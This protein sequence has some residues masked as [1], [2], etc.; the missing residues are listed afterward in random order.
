MKCRLGIIVL[1]LFLPVKSLVAENLNIEKVRDAIKTHGANWTAGETSISILSREEQKVRLG[2][3][4]HEPEPRKLQKLPPQ[5]NLPYQF[6]WRDNGGDFVTPVRDQGQCGACSYF[7]TLAA[8]EAW[9]RIRQNNPKLDIDLSEQYVLSCGSVGNCDNGAYIESI[10]RFVQR[11]GTVQETCF[12]YMAYDGA[13]CTDACASSEQ[14]KVKIGNFISLNYSQMTVGDIKNAVFHRPVAA[15]MAIFQDFYTYLDGVYQHVEGDLDGYHAV[16]IYGWDDADESWLCKNSWGIGWGNA[17]FFKIKWNE[18]EIGEPT[19]LIWDSTLGAP[20]LKVGPQLMQFKLAPG[21]KT[22]QY[23]TISN[24]G[25]GNLEFVSSV[26]ADEMPRSYFR[27]TKVDGSDGHLW[28]VSSELINGY[29]NGWLQYLDSPALD[30][31]QAKK[32]VLQLSASWALEDMDCDVSGYDGWD[33]WNVQISTDNGRTFKP[34]SPENAD[35]NCAS[36]E[37]FGDYWQLGYGIKG[38]SGLSDGWQNLNFDLTQLKSNSTIIRF[39]FASNGSKSSRDLF[40][41]FGL[42]LDDVIVKDSDKILFADAADLNSTMQ[43][44]GKGGG[45]EKWLQLPFATSN[46][47][48]G[49]DFLVPL[50]ISASNNASGW[51]TA[52]IDVNNNHVINNPQKV[53]LHL[54]VIKP[55]N[56]VGVGEIN[57]PTFYWPMLLNFT[58]TFPVNNWGTKN[59]NNVSASIKVYDEFEKEKASLNTEVADIPAG[60]SKIPAF[61]KV[62]LAN[63]GDYLLEYG[64]DISSN[65]ENDSNNNGNYWLQITPQIDDFESEKKY[66]DFGS[67]WGITEKF[68]GGYNSQ[69][70]VHVN[71]GAK[72]T[73]N[74]DNSL[75]LKNGFDLSEIESVS[76]NFWARYSMEKNKD[77]VNI[78]ARSGSSDWKT[79][80]TLSS[81]ALRWG[82]YTTNLTSFCGPGNNEVFI[83][84]QF[85][86]DEQNTGIGFFMDDLSIQI[87]E[88]TKSN[89]IAGPFIPENFILEQNYPNPFNPTTT[90]SYKLAESSQ[91]Q[92]DVLNLQGQTV[93]QLTN[94]YQVAGSHTIEWN[95]ADFA[96][97]VYLYKIDVL[98][99]TG[100]RFMDMKKMLLVK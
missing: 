96:S 95:A 24:I 59:A 68:T 35:Y 55:N 43:T 91:V 20:I 78:Q 1:L 53:I 30:L 37:S 6:S 69:Y 3:L 73:N 41:R 22:T 57:S 46:L 15:G 8:V 11:T 81:S 86:S 38:F 90:I 2:L 63:P 4:K 88:I 75:T 19:I 33:G 67:T 87:N 45:D 25:S 99:Q 27:Q 50:Q 83:R 10:H 64:L 77:F 51:Y 97:G 58:P 16:L 49:D 85:V 32:P 18:A 28:W 84:F 65:D 29:D 13:P 31:S 42:M 100:D 21:E 36:L 82:Q 98:L 7:S 12:P 71:K 79:L 93:A 39:A 80:L 72:Y 34:V 94:N 61:S 76:L 47:S 66:W 44:S 70:A 60:H 14:H 23:L 56:D 52:V 40:D 5:E 48:G 26:D 74:M 9:E 89:S 54:E 17:G 92:V 62:A